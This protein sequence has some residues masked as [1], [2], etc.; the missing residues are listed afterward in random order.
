MHFGKTKMTEGERQAAKA[1]RTS[2]K[3]GV[4]GRKKNILGKC[5]EAAKK[6]NR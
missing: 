2:R 5:G 3:G 4:K 1:T 6:I